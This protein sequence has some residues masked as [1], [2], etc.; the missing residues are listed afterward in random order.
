MSEKEETKVEPYYLREARELIDLLH[1]K[2]FLNQ[3]LSRESERW[4][5]EYIGYLFQ[6]RAEMTKK[7]ALLF[8]SFKDK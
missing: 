7:T 6:S 5:E 8:A 4:L 1:D 3:N 2:D